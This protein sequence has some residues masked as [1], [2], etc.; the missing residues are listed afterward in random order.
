MHRQSRGR[1][2]PRQDRQGWNT[3]PKDRKPA[4]F[5]GVFAGDPKAHFLHDVVDAG[6]GCR[7]L[8]HLARCPSPVACSMVWVLAALSID[9]Q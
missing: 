4:Q 6:V 3:K 2:R 7:D 5:L 9:R 1:H 8:A